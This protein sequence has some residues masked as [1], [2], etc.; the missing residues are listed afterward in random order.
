MSIIEYVQLKKEKYTKSKTKELIDNS[1][2]CPIIYKI[3]MRKL[4]LKIKHY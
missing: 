1:F 3:F 2:K 4:F